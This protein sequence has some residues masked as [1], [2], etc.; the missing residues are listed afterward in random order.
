MNASSG[1]IPAF[2]IHLCVK[3][4]ILNTRIYINKNPLF[5][6]STREL[7]NQLCSLGINAAVKTYVSYDIFNVTSEELSVAAASV[8]MEPVT[9]ECLYETPQHQHLLGI[10]LLPGQFDIRADAAMQ[11]CRLLFGHN[12]ITIRSFLLVG[13]DKLNLADLD[14]IKKH[15]IN[16]VDSSEKNLSVLNNPIAVEHLEVKVI[17]GFTE[18]STE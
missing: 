14:R 5:D 9:E 3:I 8:F 13:F 11:C 10:E 2:C 4:I 6:N 15:L 17:E 7:K 1:R 12:N 18:Y 16:P